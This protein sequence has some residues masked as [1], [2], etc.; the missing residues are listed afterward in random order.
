MTLAVGRHTRVPR[1]YRGRDI[2]WWLDRLGVLRR[3]R[4]RRLRR[5]GVAARSRRSSWWAGPIARTLD[6]RGL[7]RPRRAVVGRLAA[8]RRRAC[9]FDDDLVATTAAA[10]VKLADAAAP[11]RPRRRRPDSRRGAEPFQPHWPAFM[12][13]AARTVRSAP[14]PGSPPCSGPPAS[15]AATRGCKLP[16]STR[17]GEIVHRGGVTPAPGLF[18][19]GLPVPAPSQLQLHRRR[20]RRRARPGRARSP[21]NLG[22]R[23]ARRHEPSSA[24]AGRRRRHRRRA[25]CRRGDRTAAGARRAFTCWSSNAGRHGADT[26]ST[27]A[28]MR[29]GV[30]Q[31]HRWGLLPAIIGAGTPPIARTTFDYRGDTVAVDISARHGV[32]ALYAPRRTVLDRVLVDAAAHA[33]ADI[34]HGHRLLGLHRDPGGRVSGVDDRRRRR[35]GT[36][37][38]GGPGDRRRWAALDR[39]PPRGRRRRSA[40]GRWPPAPSTGTG[41]GI[42]ADGYRW[43]YGDHAS[44]GVIPTNDGAT[45]VFATVPAT[46]FAAIFGPDVAAGFRQVVRHLDW[47]LAGEIAAAPPLAACRASPG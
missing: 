25:L 11:H 6:L 12:D 14:R 5:R 20:R 18:V 7:R 31:L 42:T 34:R 36:P 29:G 23:K 41:R 2:L 17:R 15:G 32:D 3:A 38:A 45:C 22:A 47:Q 10:D 46:R 37:R 44:V 16:V 27:H 43:I 33:G 30:V 19:L 39:R 35:R 24:A 21:R 28:L 9:R 13:A 8:L 40:P 4:R 26:L 1:R